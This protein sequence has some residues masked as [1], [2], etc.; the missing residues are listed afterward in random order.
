MMRH[1]ATESGKSKG[2]FYTPAEV[3]HIMARVIGMDRATSPK[4]TIYDPTCGSGSLL[5]KAAAQSPVPITIYGQEMDNATRAL[6]K[7]NMILHNNPSADILQGNT[8]AAPEW[9]E[10]ETQLKTFDHVVANPPFSTKSWSNGLLVA[11]DPFRRFQYGEPPAK[12]GDYAFLLHI[13]ASMKNSGTGA[14]ILPHGVLFRGNAEAVIRRNLL[15][16]GFIKGI[17]GLPANLFYGTGIPACIIVLDKKEADSR[18]AVFMIDASK[19]F[20][21]DG[22][23][24]RLRHQ[25]VHRIVDVFTRQLEVPNYS[26]M[27]PISEILDGKNDGNLNL[28]R[29]I[30]SGEREDVQDIAA[31][32]LGGLPAADIDALEAYWDV[33][34]AVREALFA[35]GSRPGYSALRVNASELRATILEHEQF[36]AY[37]AQ[38]D[39]TLSDWAVR[40]TPTLEALEA[41]TQPKAL[42]HA[43]GEDILSTYAETPLLDAYDVYQHFMTY[44]GSVMQDDVYLIAAGGW[45]AARELRLLL[46]TPDDKGKPK[47]SEEAHFTVGSRAAQK[48][49]VADLIPPELLTARFFK[50]EQAQFDELDASAETLKRGIEELEEEHG[51]EGGLLEDARDGDKFT[52]AASKRYAEHRLSSLKFSGEVDPEEQEVLSKYLLLLEKSPKAT[53]KAREASDALQEKLRAQYAKLTVEQAREIVVHDKWLAALRAGVQAELGR[54]SSALTGR[55]RELAERY[56]QPLPALEQE[57]EALQAK[58]NAHL[59]RMGFAWA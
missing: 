24:N 20:A 43:L 6:A 12:N 55:V 51:G 35:P 34:P 41:G 5:L 2:Q 8:L 19:G 50:A 23:K 38:V 45:Q 53:K 4:Q 22:N 48:R 27:V 28:P 47:Y 18:R 15:E 25:D 30:E 37:A 54:V 33:L 39:A 46:P 52:A 9:T 58:V 26:R 14:V 44:W 29:Y 1:F 56:E 17:I 40:H 31:H 7:M 32:L 11:K 13:L 21:K 16:R 36:K 42:M 3:S 59:E 49:Y 10:S 57:A